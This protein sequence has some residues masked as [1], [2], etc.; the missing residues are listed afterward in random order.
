MGCLFGYVS[1]KWIG[2][3]GDYVLKWWRD[4]VIAVGCGESDLGR[5]VGNGDVLRFGVLFD[6]RVMRGWLDL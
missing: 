2:G 4:C 3:G 1:R 6:A 5:G